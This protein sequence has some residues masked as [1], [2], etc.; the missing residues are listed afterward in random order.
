[1]LLELL[2]EVE[3]LEE[4]D[5][6]VPELVPGVVPVEEVLEEVLGCVLVELPGEIVDDMLP[7]ALIDGSHGIALLGVVL[8]VV[9]VAVCGVGEA[10][11]GV[12][13]AVCAEGVA[14]W[15]VG[16]AVCAGGVAVCGVGDA[17]WP[18]GVAVCAAIE[19]R[20]TASRIEQ[21]NTAVF[22]F[23]Q[24]SKKLIPNPVSRVIEQVAIPW[25]P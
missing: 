24:A 6:P 1:V 23:I 18:C 13:E 14:V 9:G 2:G 15:G 21:S 17:V 12:G 19:I 22:A 8:C 20:A 4:L 10:V 25:T 5:V 3:V 7:L 11:C 16:E